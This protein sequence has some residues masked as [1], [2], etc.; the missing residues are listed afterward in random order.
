MYGFRSKA[1][2]VET[3]VCRYFTMSLAV[4]IITSQSGVLTTGMTNHISVCKHQ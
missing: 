3:S 4:R 1:A 2:V